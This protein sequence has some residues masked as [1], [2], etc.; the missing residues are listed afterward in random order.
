MLEPTDDGSD[1]VTQVTQGGG[2][3]NKEVSPSG[4]SEFELV[5][6]P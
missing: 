2:R 1:L 4:V 6:T 3:N 5:S